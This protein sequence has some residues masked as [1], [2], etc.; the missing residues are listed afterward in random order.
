MCPTTLRSV[1]RDK[2]DGQR[3]RGAQ[4]LNDEVLGLLTEW[5]IGECRNVDF[6]NGD[7]I[8]R[9]LGPN[10]HRCV[11]SKEWPFGHSLFRSYDG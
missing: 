3:V 10:D 7:V 5:L 6:A 4:C 11:S 8:Q 1:F 9:C 2:G